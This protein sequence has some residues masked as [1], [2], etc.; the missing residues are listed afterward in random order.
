MTWRLASMLALVGVLLLSGFGSA[1]KASATLAC[2]RSWPGSKLWK[3]RRRQRHGFRDPPEPGSSAGSVSPPS[4]SLSC[5]PIPM[6]IRVLAVLLS[7]DGWPRRRVRKG[8]LASA[9]ARL[10]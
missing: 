6:A 4:L 5:Q 9:E 1:P 2:L 10:T 3:C 8:R 7:A